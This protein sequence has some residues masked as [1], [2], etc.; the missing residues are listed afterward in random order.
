[1]VRIIVEKKSFTILIVTIFILLCFFPSNEGN[2]RQSVNSKGRYNDILVRNLSHE[3]TTK[4]ISN[5]NPPNYFS[6]IE[7]MELGQAAW[8][9]VL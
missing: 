3:Y 9:L 2:N 7:L 4:G 1:M 6:L 8:G 5:D